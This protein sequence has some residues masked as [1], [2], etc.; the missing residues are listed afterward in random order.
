MASG[1]NLVALI[2]RDYDEAISF[3][4]NKVGFTLLED[5]PAISTIHGH[6]KRWVVVCPPDSTGCAVL[7]AQADDDEQKAAVG[8][9][10]AGRVGMFLRT[11]NFQAQYDRMASAK[12]EFLG[13]PRDEVYG[14]VIVFRDLY[15]NKWDLLGPLTTAEGN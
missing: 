11:K 2:V 9:Q 5:S 15:G 8:R 7:L 1:I 10:W 13:E 3:Y 14:R 6:E 4:V 12:V